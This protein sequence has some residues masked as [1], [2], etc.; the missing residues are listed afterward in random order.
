[1]SITEHNARKDYIANAHFVN[2]NPDMHVTLAVAFAR[3]Q[4]RLHLLI[5]EEEDNRIKK[6]QYHE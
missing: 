1:M 6:L 4:D 3:D 5:Q 2:D